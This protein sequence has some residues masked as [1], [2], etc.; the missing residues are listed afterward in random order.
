MQISKQKAKEK[1]GRQQKWLF[2]GQVRHTHGAANEKGGDF[3]FSSAVWPGFSGP[4]ASQQSPVCSYLPK[5]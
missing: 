5:R 4:K 1:G 2:R 3:C